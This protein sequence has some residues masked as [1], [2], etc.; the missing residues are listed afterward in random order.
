MGCADWVTV[1][2]LSQIIITI[3]TAL[4]TC[5]AWLAWLQLLLLLVVQHWDYR[6]ALGLACLL[7]IALLVVNYVLFLY[8]YCLVR[9]LPPLFSLVC[10]PLLESPSTAVMPSLSQGVARGCARSH[11]CECTRVLLCSASSAWDVC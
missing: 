11:V 10:P 7:A 4:L 1:R 9:P 2:V 5:R 3:S 8:D 6:I